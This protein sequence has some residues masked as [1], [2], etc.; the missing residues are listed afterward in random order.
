MMMNDDDVRV[1][2]LLLLLQYPDPYE[3][4]VKGGGWLSLGCLGAVLL[5]TLAIGKPM[6]GRRER[7]T[8]EKPQRDRE[9]RERSERQT[10]D[11]ICV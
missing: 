5:T 4:E 7:E 2:L 6:L 1:F 11:I 8:T 3:V 9:T 10:K